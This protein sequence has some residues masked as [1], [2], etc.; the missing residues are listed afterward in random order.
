MITLDHP[1]VFAQIRG[2]PCG[3][4]P[5]RIDG[6]LSLAIK[7]QKESLLA[8]QQNRGFA[9]YVVPMETPDGTIISLVTAFFDDADEPLVIRTPLFGDEQPSVEIVAILLSPEIDIYFFDEHMREW[10]SYRCRLND[11]GSHLQSSDEIRLAAYDCETSSAIPQKLGEWFSYRTPVEDAQAIRVVLEKELWPSDIAIIDAREGANDYHGTEGFSLTTLTRDEVRPGYYQERDIVAAFKR[12]LD[13]DQ[14]ILNP[15]RRESGNEFADVVAGTY[16]TV[17]LVQAKDSPNTAKSLARSLSRKV[18]TSGHQLAKAVSQT[19]GAL[20]YARIGDPV[21]LIVNK[22]DVD[23]HIAERRILNIVIIKEVFPSQS[24]AILAAIAKFASR[25]ES[26]V[27]LDYLAFS[28]FVHHF[29]DEHRLVAEFKDFIRQVA[30]AGAW[31]DPQKFLLGRF[32][33]RIEPTG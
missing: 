8:I 28:A 16:E 9:F 22:R 11:P 1:D 4:I 19:E 17:I 6:K 10:M 29:P 18:K 26:L 31:I 30:D 33:D 14:I 32:L 5:I 2:I 20:S 3:L 24:A 27:I 21:K 12:F 15:N 23:L 25:G 7:A 13:A